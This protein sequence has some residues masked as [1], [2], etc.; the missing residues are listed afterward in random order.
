MRTQDKIIYLKLIT[1]K[2]KTKSVFKNLLFF[3]DSRSG[4]LWTGFFTVC[5]PEA[6]SERSFT[7]KKNIK[8][9]TK[10]NHIYHIYGVT[11]Q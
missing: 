8:K 7:Q 6:Y 2:H 4:R 10:E 9:K 3:N 11:S 5:G 1:R